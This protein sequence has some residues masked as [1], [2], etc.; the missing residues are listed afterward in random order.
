MQVLNSSGTLNRLTVTGT[1]FGGMDTTFGSDALLIE[2]SGTAV[3]NVTVNSNTFTSARGDHFQYSNTTAA[4]AGDV[5]FTNNTI[6]NAHPAV[7]GGGGGIR[8]VGGNNTGQN[9]SI[10]FNVSGNTMR[11][12]RG[13]AIAVNKLGGTGTYSGKIANNVVGVAGVQGSGSLEGSGIFVL[14]DGGGTYTASITGNTVRQYDNDGIFMQTGGSGVVGNG[15]MNVTVTGNTVTEPE[16]QAAGALA[17]NGFHLNGGTTVGDT[18]QITLTLS[19]NTLVGS[20]QDTIPAGSTFGDFR[21]RQR[22]STTVHLP[23]Y[24]GGATNVAA[25]VTFIQGLNPGAETGVASTNS[26][27]GGGFV[28]PLHSAPGGVEAAISP[29]PATT[30]TAAE[31]QPILAEAVRRWVATGLSEDQ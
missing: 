1:T 30:L 23:G 22:Q 9:G 7:V 2:S 20:G 31:V 10:T 19:G 25:V 5:V 16:P 3:M 6:T 11:G 17:T 27:P 26:P 15:T 8:V 24:A 4:Q 28:S 29:P 13:T 12:A 14:S 18:Y 21:L